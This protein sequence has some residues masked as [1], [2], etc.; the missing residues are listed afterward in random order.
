[1]NF[2]RFH[3]SHPDLVARADAIKFVADRLASP[4]ID[5]NWEEC[6]QIIIEEMAFISEMSL[7][8]AFNNALDILLKSRLEYLLFSMNH[9]I[10]VCIVCI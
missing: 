7:V 1:M 3:A 10:Q 5:I 4:A 8:V 9:F 6:G 2:D